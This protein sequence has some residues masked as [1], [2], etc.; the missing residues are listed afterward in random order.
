MRVSQ[1]VDK[2]TVQ[3]P[4]TTSEGESA[5]ISRQKELVQW[6]LPD[7]GSGTIKYRTELSLK[8]KKDGAKGTV[9]SEQVMYLTRPVYYGVQQGVSYDWE[10]CKA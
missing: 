2:I 10:K 3:G 7:C 5:D 9:S 8:A 1:I 6:A 4:R